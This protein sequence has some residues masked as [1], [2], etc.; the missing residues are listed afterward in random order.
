VVVVLVGKKVEIKRGR[1]TGDPYT[2]DLRENAGARTKNKEQRTINNK[3][4][5][6]Q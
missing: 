1:R 6:A 4:H 2:P 3:R 5:T